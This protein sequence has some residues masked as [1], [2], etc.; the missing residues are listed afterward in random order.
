VSRAGLRRAGLSRAGLSRAGLRR[1]WSEIFWHTWSLHN[2]ICSTVTIS[3]DNKRN[4]IRLLTAAEHGIQYY[5][6]VYNHILMYTTLLYYGLFF[7][8][9]HC[10]NFICHAF[11]HDTVS[12]G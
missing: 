9:G 8:V 10:L 1:A 11:Y 12:C 2:S 4:Y 6:R 3:R 5:S 7:F